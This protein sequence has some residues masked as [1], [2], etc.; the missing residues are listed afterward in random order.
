MDWIEKLNQAIYYIDKNL[1][2]KI[3]YDEISRIIA[4]PIA[5]FQRFFAISTGITLAE[6]IRRRKLTNAL[7][8]LRRTDEKV[9]D[10]AIKYGYESS[11]AFCV[12]FKRL[13]SITPSQAK[14]TSKDLKKYDRIFFTL[15]ITYLKG[16]N[17]MLLLNIDKYRYCEPLFEG[18]RIIL[19]FLGESYTPEYIQGISGAA[20]KIAGGCPSR[21]TGVADMFTPDFIRY[22]GY[23]IKEYPCF[24]ENGNDIFHETIEAVKKQSNL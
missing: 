5:L 18:V 10:I 12:A 2:N 7:N 17:D 13:F 22:L 16:E 4:S 24:D 19:N 14:K 9:I 21:P 1:D 15:K 23:E 8:D 6:Y 20:F 3:D 11:D